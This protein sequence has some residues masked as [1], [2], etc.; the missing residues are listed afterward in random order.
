MTVTDAFCMAGC[1]NQLVIEHAQ[2]CEA[3]NLIESMITESFDLEKLG[4]GR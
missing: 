1:H 2:H 4:G 3:C